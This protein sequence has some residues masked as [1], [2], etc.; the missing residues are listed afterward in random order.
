MTHHGTV[1][2]VG[3]ALRAAGAAVRR[4]L[5]GPAGLA[6]SQVHPFE[7]LL[8]ALDSAG[9]WNGVTDGE[10]A[11]VLAALRT[12]DEQGATW[13]AGGLWRA[14][15]E[16]LGK[17]DVELWLAGM[18]RALADCGVDLRVSNVL[19]PDDPASTGY[20]VA[21]NGT[22]L[23]LYDFDPD[24]P[25]VPASHDPWTDCSVIPAAEVNRLLAAAGS[26]RR[27]ALVWPGSQDGVCV[28]GHREVLR[29]AAA[30]AAAEAG[31][32]GLVVP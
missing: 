4:E 18:T 1:N 11:A 19:S 6:A 20:A 25:R 15:G 21:V 13:A 30:G 8:R 3:R 16:D 29:R 14:D 10:R 7:D 5:T 24:A 28:L 9:L 23:N 32:W 31:A 12:S 26:D 2:V 17:G 27:L 22:T